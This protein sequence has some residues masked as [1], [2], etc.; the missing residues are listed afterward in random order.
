MTLPVNATILPRR[1]LDVVA[2]ANCCPYSIGNTTGVRSLPPTLHFASSELGSHQPVATWLYRTTNKQGRRAV[3]AHRESSEQPRT[4]TSRANPRSLAGEDDDALP[5]R[6]I[7]SNIVEFF[8]CLS[9][10]LSVFQAGSHLTLS[11]S[12][13]V[14]LS[15][16]LCISGFQHIYASCVWTMS[17]WSH[18]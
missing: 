17:S 15:L 7:S 1:W 14:C 8:S 6:T 16:S 9:L 10:S 3:G 18:S 5:S 13:P 2:F 12:S 11:S 4:S